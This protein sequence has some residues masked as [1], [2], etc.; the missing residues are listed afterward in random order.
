[1]KK[2]HYMTWEERVQLEAL[3]KAKVPVAEIARILRFTR[4]TVYNE[5][6]RGSY[7]HTYDYRDK[8]EYSAVKGQSLH[9]KAQRHKGGKKKG[10]SDPEYMDFLAYMIK[11]QHYSPAAALAAARRAGYQ[12][13]IC[14]ATLYSYIENG[15]FKRLGNID[16]PEKVSRR[17]KKSEK[18]SRVSHPKLPSIEQRPEWVNDR[19][20]VGHW[21][22]DL[23]VGKK[24]SAP[25][26][27][28]LT[29]RC[30]RRELIRKI[31]NKQAASIRSVFDQLEKQMGKKKFRETFVSLTTDNG[32]EFME[33]DLLRKSIY[34]GNRFDL[35]Y[36]HSYAAWEKGT[37]EN[38]NRM[39]R[40]FFPKGT[41]FSKVSTKRIREVEDWMNNYPRKIFDWAT[42]NE[43]T[44]QASQ[45]LSGS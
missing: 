15:V 36:C 33:Y 37:N 31:P 28:T 27:L 21:E 40:K 17:T 12:T 10:V 20:E 13:S 9:D 39:I 14:T 7:L 18:R 8:W 16:L 34:K 29:E 2:Q 19:S 25:C 6:R 38:H 22:M 32:S 1:M 35:W 30:S 45:T 4:Q 42:P 11:R 24:E 43:M 5:I 26:L 41:D 23:I 44:Y 3:R